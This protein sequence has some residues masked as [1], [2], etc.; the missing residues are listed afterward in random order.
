MSG[1]PPGPKVC[2]HDNCPPGF[3]YNA[4]PPPPARQD[5]CQP[6]APA[7]EEGERCAVR[8]TKLGDVIARCNLHVAHDSACSFDGQTWPEVCAP[9]PAPP[10][11]GKA[12]QKGDAMEP[13]QSQIDR[14]AAFIIREVPGE[15]SQNE[16]AI[17]TAIRLIRSQPL[18]EP[19][20]EIRCG[21][22]NCPHFHAEPQER[23][24]ER[25]HVCVHGVCAPGGPQGSVNKLREWAAYRPHNQLAL[26][27]LLAAAHARGV[28]EGLQMAE[29][30]AGDV[31]TGRFMNDDDEAERG[32]KMVLDCIAAAKEA[33][34]G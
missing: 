17:D 31:V 11:E 32:A 8:V 29:V 20:V 28:A 25:E 30:I 5:G 3:C 13:L 27:H 10:Q 7:P 2:P 26:D 6:L 22:D 33:A 1:Y 4:A 16:G 34:R 15:P 14:L 21:Y 24:E 12:T 18:A 9:A 19:P 23:G